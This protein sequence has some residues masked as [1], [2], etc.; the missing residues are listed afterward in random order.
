MLVAEM[1]SAHPSP[2]SGVDAEALRECI[3][4][5]LACAQACTSCANACLNEDSV[6][7]LRRCIR[8]DLDCADLCSALARILTR[9]TDTAP[10]L[11]RAA[12]TACIEACRA[13]G[14]ECAGHA[15]MHEHCRICAEAC[16]ACE[17]A[18][19]ALDLSAA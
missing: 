15:E 3:E 6:A 17:K 13:C 7:E 14:D 16:R 12:V 9:G 11:L 4:A 2:L 10:A 8:T 19:R 1:Q 18:C 5:C